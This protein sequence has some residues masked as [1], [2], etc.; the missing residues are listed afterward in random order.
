MG[1]KMSRCSIMPPLFREVFPVFFSH[2][3]I[4]TCVLAVGYF[5]PRPFPFTFWH[6]VAL[7]I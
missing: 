3:V 7:S 5:G 2:S 6:R 1:W 4:P